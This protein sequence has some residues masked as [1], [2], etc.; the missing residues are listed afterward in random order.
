MRKIGLIFY[1]Q[2]VMSHNS[3]VWFAV[4]SEKLKEL[5]LKIL[6]L[7][8]TFILW[9]AKAFLVGTRMS[10]GQEKLVTSLFIHN[11]FWLLPRSGLLAVCVCVGLCLCLQ[12][13]EKAKEAGRK[14]RALVRQREQSG[15][16]DH[17]NLDLTYSVSQAAVCLFYT[18]HSWV[19]ICF[20]K[21]QSGVDFLLKK[22]LF[23]AWKTKLISDK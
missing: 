7:Q 8:V 19:M 20:L 18:L 16:A 10:N 21:E 17:I 13:L 3:S 15:S 23:N 1:R 2:C 6:L 5:F 4:I 11:Y 12:A 9:K 14:E 22:L